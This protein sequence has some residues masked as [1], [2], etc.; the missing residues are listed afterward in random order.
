MATTVIFTHENHLELSSDLLDLSE[1]RRMSQNRKQQFL[2]GRW[3]IRSQASK[4]LN[5]RPETIKFQK[6]GNK[7]SIVIPQ[8][9]EISL[10]HSDNFY[11]CAIS[12][13]PVGIDIENI[14]RD[15]DMLAIAKRYYNEEDLKLINLS[16]EPN[17][18][19]LEMWVKKEAYTKYLGS[20]IAK[21]LNKPIPKDLK[22]DIRVINNFFVACLYKSELKKFE[23]LI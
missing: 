1:S 23:I 2:K 8:E 7:R 9:I 13:E 10:A 4:Y 5:C 22:V 11:A 20:S 21:Q 14:H 12:S 16:E 17:N 18:L 15:I 3:L 6:V 19:A